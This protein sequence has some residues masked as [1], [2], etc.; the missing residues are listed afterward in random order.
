M[1]Q[2]AADTAMGAAATV[3]STEE[4]F[5]IKTVANDALSAVA[6]ACFSPYSGA[7]ETMYSETGADPCAA[8]GAA[9][10]A[11]FALG[12]SLWL[13]AA[14]SLWQGLAKIREGWGQRI[15]GA[16]LM[17]GAVFAIWLQF[18]PGGIYCAT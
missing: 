14:P 16:L 11:L 17:A 3:D 10:M 1:E 9:A 12:S 13:L 15:A 4:A 7:S 6:K 18:Q 8:A 2:L 5:T